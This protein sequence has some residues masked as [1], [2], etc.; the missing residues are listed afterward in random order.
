MKIRNEVRR[1]RSTA[2][3]GYVLV[4]VMFLLAILMLSLVVA[5]PRIKLALERDR[6]LEAT[7]RGK[8]YIRAI[9]LYYQKFHRYPPNLDAL[10]MTDD[11]RFLRKK[12]VDPITGK[13]DWSPIQFGQNKVATTF[14]FFG[15]EIGGTPI[16]GTGP[17]G[18]GSGGSFSSSS[19]FSSQNPSSGSA[20]SNS[21]GSQTVGGSSSDSASGQTFGGTGIIG[22]SI[23]SEK[24][25]ILVYKKQNHFNMWE[26]VYDPME[27]SIARL[28]GG[29]G[30]TTGLNSGTPG[31]TDGNL[32]TGGAPG[33]SP[34]PVNSPWGP[35]GNL[36]TSGAP[37]SGAPTNGPWGPNGNLPS[38][39]P[40]Q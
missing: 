5:A 22:F 35:N 2:E 25:S 1:R 15:A 40:P 14:G 33:L 31:S 36:P 19:V 34:P 8:Q 30:A 24:Q 13:D 20:S 29:G 4:A 16:A 23:P 26:F 12:Y 6:E 9:R 18:T 28:G 32:P 11:V 17:G 38:P 27:G 37:G 10:V 7:H 21:T 39:S 3:D